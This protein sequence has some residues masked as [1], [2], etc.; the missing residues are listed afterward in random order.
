MWWVPEGHRP[1]PQE[2]RERLDYLAAHGPSDYAFGWE[3]LNQDNMWMRARCACSAQQNEQDDSI[4]M[5]KLI[6][7]EK[8]IEVEEGLNLLQA[9]EMAGE[10]IPRFCYHERLSIAG[11]CR[12]A[13]SRWWACPSPSP[14]AIWP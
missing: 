11:N 3:S 10:E 1:S 2:G 9:C 13:W 12:C 8:P 5:P 7:N 4:G 6:I 14:P